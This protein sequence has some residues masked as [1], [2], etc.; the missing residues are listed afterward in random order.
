MGAGGLFCV[1]DMEMIRVFPRKTNMTPSDDKVY[2]TGPPLVDLEDRDVHVSVTFTEDKPRAEKLAELWRGRDYDVKIG[3]PAYDDR[4]GEFVPGRYV[5]HGAVM[6]SRGCNNNCWFCKVHEREGCIRELR[7]NDGYNVLDSNLLQ[8]SRGHI[9]AVFDML[10]YQSKPIEFTGG[11]EAANLQD[12]HCKLLSEIRLKSMFFAY[13]TPSDWKPLKR[14]KRL[15]EKHMTI[16]RHKIFVYVLIGY[17]EDEKRNR[18]EDTL[19]D[20]LF[21]LTRVK[22]LGFCPFAMLYKDGMPDRP[23]WERF[24]RKWCRPAE[25]YRKKREENYFF[26]EI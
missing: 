25:I 6:T 19:K 4:G 21:R 11:L 2:F 15:L 26:L 9:E 12:W 14:A 10:F 8:C 17:P 24:Q 5:K 20:A 16:D 22:D 13:D 3:G 7:I 23:D 18:P 1:G